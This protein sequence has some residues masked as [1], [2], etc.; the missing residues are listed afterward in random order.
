MVI[1]DIP[2]HSWTWTWTWSWLW[3]HHGED[4]LAEAADVDVLPLQGAVGEDEGEAPAGGMQPDERAG[5]AGVA[6]AGAVRGVVEDVP[7]EAAG[8]GVRAEHPAQGVRLEDLPRQEGAAEQ[9]EVV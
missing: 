8:V 3:V 7:A 5:E 9:G 2:V 1:A 6:H 4:F